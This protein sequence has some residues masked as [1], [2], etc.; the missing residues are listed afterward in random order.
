MIFVSVTRL[1]LRLW[2]FLPAFLVEALRA[3]M[4][5]RS[6]SGNRAVALMRDARNAFWTCTVW[7]D[8]KAMRSFM[9]SGIHRRAMPRLP[10]WCDEAAVVHWQQ[11]GRDLPD[12]QTVYER[13]QHEGRPSRVAHP[14]PNQESFQIVAPRLKPLLEL[15]FL[16]R[17][18]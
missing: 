7:D 11:G 4:Q 6:A 2:G 17:D 14:S 12:W 13:L 10:D 5:A 8:E 16:K 9:L 3:T 15:R 18:R 1:R